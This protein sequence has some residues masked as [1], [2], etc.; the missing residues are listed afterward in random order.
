VRGYAIYRQKSKWENFVADGEVDVVEVITADPLAHRSLW[1]FLTRVDLFPRVEWWNLPVDDPLPASVTD[2]R[3]IRR[4]VADGLWVRLMNVPE[5]IEARRYESDGRV[6]VSVTDPTRPATGGTF[7]IE[8]E[9][10]QAS[11]TATNV[12]PDVSLGIDVLGHLYL[13]G[14]NALTM[15]RA[16]RITGDPEAVRALHRVFRTDTAPWCPEVF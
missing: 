14:G 10:G 9:G 11:C 1:A 12:E 4:S 5:A 13:G 15:A 6:T 2:Q 7:V 16:G 8:V 3:R